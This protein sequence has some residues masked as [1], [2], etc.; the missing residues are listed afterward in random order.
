M[1]GSGRA[2]AVRLKNLTC[3]A[4]GEAEVHVAGGPRAV[5]AWDKEYSNGW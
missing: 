4:V 5:A 1:Q 2:R 3:A